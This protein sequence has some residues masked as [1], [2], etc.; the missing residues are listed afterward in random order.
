MISWCSASRG[1]KSDTCYNR[2]RISDFVEATLSIIRHQDALQVS[3][4]HRRDS[5]GL[6]S[7]RDVYGEMPTLQK[8]TAESPSEVGCLIAGSRKDFQSQQAFN[9]QENRRIAGRHN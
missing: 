7:L 1:A 3:C 4:R 6:L 8:C 2:D 5:W 9:R